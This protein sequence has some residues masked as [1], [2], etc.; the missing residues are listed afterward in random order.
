MVSTATTP[1]VWFL[2]GSD[3]K[4]QGP[5]PF[6]V[7][8]ERAASGELRPTD[9]VWREGMSS[10][11]AAGQVQNLSFAEQGRVSAPTPFTNAA[12]TRSTDKAPVDR[13]LARMASPE[14]FHRCSKFSAL[15]AAV[16]AIT[17]LGGFAF[18]VSWFTGAL[19][20]V[21]LAVLGQGIAAI[22]E[23]LQQQTVH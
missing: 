19:L 23:A 13:M 2:A 4:Q 14:F 15:A 12:S 7:V 11:A 1:D 3:G 17:S 22:L 6:A 21:I 16:L 8:K 9:F 20:F 10:W 18:G 5:F